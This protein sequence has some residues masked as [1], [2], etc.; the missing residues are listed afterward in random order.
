MKT[1]LQNPTVR[2]P[3]EF[4]E[5]SHFQSTRSRYDEHRYRA[6][7]NHVPYRFVCNQRI[8][9]E[10]IRYN[11]RIL[12]NIRYPAFSHCHMVTQVGASDRVFCNPCRIAESC[13]KPQKSRFV[14]SSVITQIPRYGGTLKS[15]LYA[16]RTTCVSQCS[17]MFGSRG[18]AWRQH[19]RRQSQRII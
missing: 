14:S 4:I 19:R 6:L 16:Q 15:S 10:N 5:R 18:V 1:V 9:R 2:V 13:C 7:A 12:E 17:A 3:A 11:L 8:T